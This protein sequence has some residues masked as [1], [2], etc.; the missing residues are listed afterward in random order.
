MFFLSTGV[1]SDGEVACD[2]FDPLSDEC[3]PLMA[4]YCDPN[5]EGKCWTLG[6]NIHDMSC[7]G[8]RF[9][10]G[11]NVED[12]G[13]V[14]HASWTTLEAVECT[15]N[16]LDD[17]ALG[18]VTVANNCDEHTSSE[19]KEQS[20]SQECVHNDAIHVSLEEIND[21]ATEVKCSLV[22]DPSLRS[23]LRA[24][25]PQWS[26]KTL[27]AVVAKLERVGVDTL[28]AFI[29]VMQDAGRK[30]LNEMLK[31]SR[32][33]SFS[34]ETLQAFEKLSNSAANV[35]ADEVECR[36]SQEQRFVGPIKQ[37]AQ[38]SSPVEVATSQHT[39][40]GKHAH[41][42]KPVSSEI[43]EIASSKA[44][45]GLNPVENGLSMKFP[46]GSIETGGSCNDKPGSTAHEDKCT[47]GVGE[48]LPVRSFQVI[49]PVVFVREQPN[50]DSQMID[51]K[52]QGEIIQADE[53]SFNG[54]VHLAD[55]SDWISRRIFGHH[56][57]NYLPTLMPACRN[58]ILQVSS[59]VARTAGPTE[60]EVV[61]RPHIPARSTP[62]RSGQV[63]GL[64]EAGQKIMAETQTYHGWVRLADGRSW[65]L[66]VD[67]HHGMLLRVVGTT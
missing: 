17:N 21:G 14:R 29:L 7:E 28:P 32:E 40:V 8:A 47:T 43:P 20:E 27:G 19:Q 18:A 3:D 2:D 9:E 64:A 65:M 15:V 57:R 55:R 44:N 1:S 48:M 63:V 31:Q 34:Q 58:K 38:L 25:R 16:S 22:S 23:A 24:A 26:S 4:W 33:K 61:F 12:D 62:L 54:W 41:I 53:E 50:L 51:Y 37:D 59:E 42:F 52:M 56:V 13:S 66:G 36:Q 11:V 30:R 46:S 35:W 60:L 49:H 39:A 45:Q 6:A 5:E 10:I 67:E